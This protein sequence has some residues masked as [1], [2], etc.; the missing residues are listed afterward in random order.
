MQRSIP[1]DDIEES[2]LTNFMN[3]KG[4]AEY[5][6]V[7]SRTLSSWRFKGRG[8]KFFKFHSNVRY[9]K[10]HLD[11]FIASSCSTGGGLM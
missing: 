2:K 3:E 9:A 7:P 8:P 11:Q 4:A 5:L 10:E 6:S 1:L